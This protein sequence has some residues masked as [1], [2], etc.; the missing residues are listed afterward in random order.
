MQCKLIPCLT[1]LVCLALFAGPGAESAERSARLWTEGEVRSLAGGFEEVLLDS[2]NC[3]LKTKEGAA[4]RHLVLAGRGELHDFV[5][6]EEACN[7][8]TC[9]RMASRSNHL[10]STA[11]ADDNTLIRKVETAQY[12]PREGGLKLTGWSQTKASDGTGGDASVSALLRG[13]AKA[14]EALEVKTSAPSYRSSD[15][16]RNWRPGDYAGPLWPHVMDPEFYEGRECPYRIRSRSSEFREFSGENSGSCFNGGQPYCD[17]TKVMQQEC[18]LQPGGHGPGCATVFVMDCDSTNQDCLHGSC[19]DR[20]IGDDDPPDDTTDFP[21]PPDD[22]PGGPE[23]PGG[24]PE[25][26]LV[27][28]SVFEVTEEYGWYEEGEVVVVLGETVSVC[29]SWEE[30]EGADNDGDGICDAADAF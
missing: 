13:N 25:T 6:A 27:C 8:G 29:G 3:Q 19:V 15:D 16:P 24:D 18:R 11:V 5:F 23:G 22:G 4:C 1:V 26:C 12:A 20:P 9:Y 17:G 14:I 2:R 28:T 21:E 10:F 7:S 30:R